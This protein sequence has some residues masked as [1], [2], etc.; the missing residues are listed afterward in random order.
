MSPTPQHGSPAGDAALAIQRLARQTGGDVQ[1]LQT[2]YVLESMLAR[3][4]V[5]VYRDD[6]VFYA[7]GWVMPSC[8]VERR[9]PAVAGR[10]NQ[11]F[12]RKVRSVSVGL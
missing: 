11:R 5:S 6:F 10:H 3:L 7:D 4:A 8:R 12:S 9:G 1:E 2:L